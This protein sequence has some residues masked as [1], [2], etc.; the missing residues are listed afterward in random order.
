MEV[1]QGVLEELVQQH[2]T[3]LVLRV[4]RI[5]MLPQVLYLPQGMVADVLELATQLVYKTLRELSLG[6]V[7]TALLVLQP[8]ELLVEK[9][10]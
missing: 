8:L 3:L 9:V 2:L 1:L 10:E 4:V 7:V 5:T 6:L